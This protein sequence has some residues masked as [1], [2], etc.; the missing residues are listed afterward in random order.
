MKSL[1]VL[2][3]FKRAV[4]EF[5]SCPVV[6]TEATYERIVFPASVLETIYTLPKFKSLV[7]LIVMVLAPI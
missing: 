6:A 7:L 3:Q 4:L 2:S 1:P 5:W